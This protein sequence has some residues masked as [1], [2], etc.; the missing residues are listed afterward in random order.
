[1]RGAKTVSSIESRKKE[2][3]R[4]IQDSIEYRVY[5]IELRKKKNTK[6]DVGCRYSD[7]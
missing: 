2:K 4:K 5:S 3:K 7:E 6:K 1:V